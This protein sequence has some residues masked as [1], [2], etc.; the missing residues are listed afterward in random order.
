M[1]ENTKCTTNEIMFVHESEPAEGN[2]IYIQKTKR[3]PSLTSKEKKAMLQWAEEKQSWTVHGW[4]DHSSALDKEMMLELGTGPVKLEE[5][6]HISTI[7]D[8]TEL[9][10]AITSTGNDH[11]QQTVWISIQS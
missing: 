1:S 10:E 11:G 5:N 4:M 3:K 6:K 7:T 9:M 8:D 2:G